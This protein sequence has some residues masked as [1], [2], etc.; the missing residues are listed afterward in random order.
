MRPRHYNIW[1]V[2]KPAPD[3][4]G[5]WIVHCLDV[6]VV[7]Q[8]NSP[9]HAFQMGAEAATLFIFDELDA[10][11]EPLCCRAPDEYWD[12]L[13][14]IMKHGERADFDE[15][16]MDGDTS[17]HM[18]VQAQMILERVE[19]VSASRIPS[20]TTPLFLADACAPGAFCG[21]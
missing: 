1:F 10:G 5:Q 6:D 15:E 2:V 20:A 11:R 18:A 14:K 8:G 13:R 17:V 3:V 19:R 9:A 7:S 21:A 12:E 16:W 4:K